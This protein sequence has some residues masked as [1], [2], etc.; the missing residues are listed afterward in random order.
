MDRIW[1][2]QY[3][4]PQC[5]SFNKIHLFTRSV[6]AI[7]MDSVCQRIAPMPTPLHSHFAG[8]LRDR[9]MVCGG[10]DGVFER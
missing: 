5:K 9:I 10:N 6:E 4:D 1:L 2:F 8:R 3:S 7:G